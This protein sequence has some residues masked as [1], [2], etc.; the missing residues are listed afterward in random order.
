MKFLRSV[1]DYIRKDQTKIKIREEMNIFNLNVK[2]IK[3]GSQ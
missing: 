3:Y 1:A 2:I